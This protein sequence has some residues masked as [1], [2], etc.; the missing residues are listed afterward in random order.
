MYILLLHSISLQTDVA[1]KPRWGHSVTAFSLT[2]EL[3]EVTT[4]GGSAEAWTGVSWLQSKLAHTTIH[5][6]CKL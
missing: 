4:F 6:F 5:Q 1:L 2:P 3:T